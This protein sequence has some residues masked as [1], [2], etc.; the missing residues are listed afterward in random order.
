M[1]F[2]L[3]KEEVKHIAHLARLRVSD[4]EVALYASQLTDILRYV[5]QLN[6]L[7]TS[8]VQ[9]TSHALPV[10]NVFRD[11]VPGSTLTPEQA[12]SNAPKSSNDCFQVPKVLDQESA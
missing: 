8:D 9:P 12:L 1:D 11:D 6:K 2:S 10:T 4:E 7:D 3:G 5:T